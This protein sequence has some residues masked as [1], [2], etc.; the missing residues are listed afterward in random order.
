MFQVSQYLK[1][2]SHGNLPTGG[3]FIAP[4]EGTANGKVIV[5]GSITGIG[6]IKAPLEV[7]IENGY[8][9]DFVGPN[10]YRLREILG[11]KKEKWNIV[12]LGIGKN[13]QAHLIG[14]ILE[15]EKIYR[16]VHIAFGEN[17]TFVGNTIRSEEFLN[18]IV[19]A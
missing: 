9:T 5:D 19:K 11:T 8:A 2:G 15:D 17:S 4:V 10:A 1:P 7:K 3:A 18:K 13:P 6:S 16:T 14:N 12:E